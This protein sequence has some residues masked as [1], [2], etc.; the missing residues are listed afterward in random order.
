MEMIEYA[1]KDSIM[2]IKE[3]YYIY[4]FKQLNEFIKEQKSIKENDNQN[5]MFDIV[6]RHRSI[7]GNNATQHTTKLC[8]KEITRHH[9]D[10]GR[11]T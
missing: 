9:N 3:N 4:Q 7:T 1:K 6:I 5:S 8:K 10:T 2:N 11:S